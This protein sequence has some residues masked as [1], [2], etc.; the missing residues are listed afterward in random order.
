MTKSSQLLRTALCLFLLC[1]M[2]VLSGCPGGT[3]PTGGS[4]TTSNTTTGGQKPE[5]PDMDTTSEEEASRLQGTTY[6]DA[7]APAG[8]GASLAADSLA[9]TG[10]TPAESGI[11]ETTASGF[12]NLFRRNGLV[13]NATYRITDGAP[14]VF[15]DSTGM[16]YDGKNVRL[17][18]DAGIEIRTVTDF[19]LK[20]LTLVSAGTGITVSGSTDVTFSGVEVAGTAGT[21]LALDGESV[22]VTLSD[23][24]VAG[25]N[26]VVSASEDLYILDSAL[27]ATDTALTDRAA[28]L[29]VF[30]RRSL[31]MGEKTGL[32]LSSSQADIRYAD[33]SGPASSVA[34]RGE[35]GAREVLFA[36]CRFSGSQLSVH[37]SEVTNAV[38]LFS[39]LT[40]LLAAD[41]ESVFVC[42]NTVSGELSFSGNRYLLINRNAVEE[43]RIRDQDNEYGSGDTIRDLDARAEA[44][45]NEDLLPQVNKELFVGRPRAEY[46]RTEDREAEQTLAY[47]MMYGEERNGVLIVAPGAYVLNQTIRLGIENSGLKVYA[48]GV[49]GE[50]NSYSTAVIS[51]YAVQGLE[52][53]GLFVDYVYNTTGQGVVLSKNAAANTV[54]I[55]AGAGMLPDWTD[56]IY[57]NWR[58]PYGSSYGYRAGHAEPYADMGLQDVQYNPETRRMTLTYSASNF[59]MIRVGDTICIRGKGSGGTTLENCRDVVLEDMTIYGAAGFGFHETYSQSQTL[60]HRVAVTTGPSPIITEEE[61]EAYA[62]LGA[63]YEVDFSVWQDEEGRY[64]GTRRKISTVDATHTTGA[65]AGTRVVSCVFESMCDDGTNQGHIYGLLQ[66]YTENGDG[67]VTLRYGANGGRSCVPFV[68]GQTVHVYTPD[69][70][71]ICET[72]A[73]SAQRNAGILYEVDVA[74]SDC[75]LALLSDYTLGQD[76]IFV[77][78]LSRASDGFYFDN[79]VVRN[80]RSRG[81]LLKSSDATVRYC[82][83]VNIGMGAI[84]VHYEADWGEAGISRNLV[85]ENNYIENTGYYNPENRIYAAIS[86]YGLNQVSSDADYM[87]YRNI[88]ISGNRIV[89]RGA[90]YAMSINSAMDVEITGNEIGASEYDASGAPILLYYVRDILLADNIFPEGM[91]DAAARVETDHAASVTGPDVGGTVPET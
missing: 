89:N 91:T 33:I 71:L 77:D 65:V 42:E 49:L 34:V 63:F 86:V 22:R 47:Q 85:L 31:L 78:N 10:R 60:M 35:A 3:P 13:E 88:R 16:T 62:D 66:D 67:T 84:A 8:A 87:L 45:A 11:V 53:R 51:A 5:T 73:R 30:L 46:V 25:K 20:N 59:A 75:N 54:T 55:L 58:D 48:Y 32:L 19:M 56:E 24:R 38:V 28:E 72:P 4:T 9:M 57:Y 12:F 26:A 82:T 79:T 6:P 44:G 74:A 83:L 61:Y 21:A 7:T 29:G 17:L 64:R 41:S 18:S 15:S 70:R 36:Y 50:K 69:G 68:K 39:G 76:R 37:L 23:C 80:I 43:G 14:V 90:E 2:L 52:I 1:A 81:L 27:Y 40:N